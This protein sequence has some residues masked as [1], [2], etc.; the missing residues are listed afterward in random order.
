MLRFAETTTM[1]LDSR[2]PGLVETSRSSNIGDC[3]FDLG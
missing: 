2:L 1:R 3:L